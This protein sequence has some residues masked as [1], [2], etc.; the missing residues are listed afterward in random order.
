MA[1]EIKH[2]FASQVKLVFYLEYVILQSL[3]F[4]VYDEI[5][6]MSQGS[7]ESLRRCYGW[8]SHFLKKLP[9]GILS[10]TFCPFAL[11]MKHFLL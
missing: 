2:F 10:K 5:L 6:F 1:Q 9:L 3:D 8:I 7:S 4:G 11:N